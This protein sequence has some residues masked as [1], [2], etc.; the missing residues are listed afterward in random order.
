MASRSNKLPPG[1]RPKV[2]ANRH[3]RERSHPDRSTTSSRS[4][5]HKCGKS[6]KQRTKDSKQTDDG[7]STDL[8][9]KSTGYRDTKVSHEGT[10]PKRGHR[11]TEDSIP[12]IPSE[13]DNDRQTRR[14]RPLSIKHLKDILKNEPTEI[15]ME[16]AAQTSGWQEYLNRENT[17]RDVMIFLLE[18]IGKAC[19][20]T[21]AP[22]SRIQFLLIVF[23]S[24]FFS[25]Y[26]PTFI[27]SLSSI[28]M[29]DEDDELQAVRHILK[30]LHTLV[31]C[32]PMG[33]LDNVTVHAAILDQ[34]CK[35][36]DTM[37]EEVK[38][39]VDRLT[40][41]CRAIQ[42]SL[43]DSHHRQKIR[44]QYEA[45][46]DNFRRI[47]IIPDIEEIRGNQKPFLRKNVVKGQYKDADDY[48]DVQFRL[49]RE[50]LVAPLRHGIAEYLQNKREFDKDHHRRL[51]DAFLYHG[52]RIVRPV[53]TRGGTGHLLQFDTSHFNKFRWVSSK[54]LISGSLLCLTEDNFKSVLYATVEGRDPKQLERG[55]I[56]VRFIEPGHGIT[57]TRDVT[58][59]MVET[60]AF[61]ESYRYVLEGLKEFTEGTLPMAQYITEANIKSKPP[62]YLR[63]CDR[64]DPVY[65]L[66][67][68][69]NVQWKGNDEATFLVEND[70]ESGSTDSDSTQ[71]GTSCADSACSES[72]SR[73]QNYMRGKLRAVK[74]LEP[75][76]WPEAKTLDFDESQLAAFRAALTSE[77]VLIQG[78]P[79]TGK[80]YVG[81]KIVKTLLQNCQAQSVPEYGYQDFRPILVVC[82]TNHAL[83][84]F[85]EGIYQYEKA[86]VRVGG[87]CSSDKLQKCCIANI[88]REKRSAKE[89]PAYIQQ[90]RSDM[91][92]YYRYRDVLVEA[93]ERIALAQ[94][95]VLKPT[96]LFEENI[97]SNEQYQNLMSRTTNPM[98]VWL[99]LD[100]KGIPNDHTKRE[101]QSTA[102]EDG[103]NV[104]ELTHDD[105]DAQI[106]V[107]EEA[108]LLEEQREFGNDP[109]VLKHKRKSRKKLIS[110]FAFVPGWVHS[111]DEYQSERQ[112][113]RQIETAIENTINCSDIMSASESLEAIPLLG[114]KIR[115]KTRRNYGT[116]S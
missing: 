11:D 65:D 115:S 76:A 18:I 72:N 29:P 94:T 10:R 61:F 30:L 62:R 68:V 53:M 12:D 63:N 88:R 108:A 37:P 98:Y 32:L 24:Q 22:K 87:R 84:Q 103:V 3:H 71:N 67:Q 110:E 102:V 41:V 19:E 6:K 64:P 101:V 17:R 49:L 92:R 43:E 40:E 46:P 80:T 4:S 47:Q 54:R 89:I 27:T 1:A 20:C 39:D 90:R 105:G 78:P 2:S 9:T 100:G 97:M 14:K 91:W 70:E 83:D 106:D 107:M 116:S 59:L 33:T 15:V 56:A 5:R 104:D 113:R 31:Q 52:V 13:I 69:A 74:V 95:G 16:L 21:R 109:V 75:G 7:S 66:R 26:L 73:I 85:L 25:R 114:V 45:P 96:T 99:G 48:L 8:N 51:Q 44:S 77:F 38:M 36:N 42:N 111:E 86:I 81:L 34:L 57:R 55:Q 93:H 60:S 50:D 79:G 112:D 28:K 58:F 82:Y 23:R 35:G